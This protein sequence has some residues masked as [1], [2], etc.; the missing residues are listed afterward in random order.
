MKKI[1]SI[2]V[3]VLIIIVIVVLLRS[4]AP[5]DLEKSTVEDVNTEDTNLTEDSMTDDDSTDEESSESNVSID[6]FS[7]TGYGPGKQHVGTFG[8]Y[9]VSGVSMNASGLPTS[10]T[11]TFDASTITADGG[12]K[13]NEHLCS[14]EFFDCAVYPDVTFDLT[15]IKADS[16]EEYT[17]TGN[18][19]F[20]GV[21]KQISFGVTRDGNNFSAD[22]TI[23]TTPFKFKFIGV[24]KDV[25]IQFSGSI[26]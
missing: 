25:R 21:T 23:D 26:K 15:N 12:D 16:A 24:D 7:F 20:H 14:D 3:I 9:E 10:G 13:L 4:G 5:E 18:L 22:F 19:S 6:S 17:V 2:L 1:V 11:I 8:S